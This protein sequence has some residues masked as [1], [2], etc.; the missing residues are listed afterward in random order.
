MV[1]VPPPTSE[2][3]C[4]LG[5]WGGAG[6]PSNHYNFGCMTASDLLFTVG[7]WVFRVKL[8]DK[9]ITDIEGLRD[10]AIATTFWLPSGYNFG[11]VIAIE[12]TFDS[13]D[14]FLRLSYPMKI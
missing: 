9:D 10:V 8:S 6:K 7:G 13:R 11:C 12:S 5:A 14:E 2:I 3:G 1:G 4:S